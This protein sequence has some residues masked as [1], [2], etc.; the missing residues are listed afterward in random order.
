MHYYDLVRTDLTQ[1]LSKICMKLINFWSCQNII[2]GIF[3]FILK[4]FCMTECGTQGKW[5]SFKKI[6]FKTL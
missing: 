1:T 2:I 3:Y 4:L 6:K 5:N